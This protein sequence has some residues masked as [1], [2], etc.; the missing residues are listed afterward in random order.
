[1]YMV[2]G[3]CSHVT[4]AGIE[5]DSRGADDPTLVSALHARTCSGYGVYTASLSTKDR[6]HHAAP[7]GVPE[8][9]PRRAGVPTSK[10]DQ[11][12]AARDGLVPLQSLWCAYAQHCV[13]T[14]PGGL[15]Q[16]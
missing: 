3:L 16:T 10:E 11:R 7:E 9:R 15:T 2:L 8:G 13:E 12:L 4:T 1:V 6:T 5:P 14:P